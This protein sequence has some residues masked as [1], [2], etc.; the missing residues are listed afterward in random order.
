MDPHPPAGGLPLIGLT[1]VGLLPVELTLL[2]R[3][4][5]LGLAL[6][7]IGRSPDFGFSGCFWNEPSLEPK[8][9]LTEEPTL[10]R[11]A[12]GDTGVAGE[13]GVGDATVG[14]ARRAG[15]AGVSVAV[16]DVAAAAR[17]WR[18]AS[19]RELTSDRTPSN[20]RKMD[21]DPAANADDTASRVGASDS[22]RRKSCNPSARRIPMSETGFTLPSQGCRGSLRS[23]ITGSVAASQI[24]YAAEVRNAA[25]NASPKGTNGFDS[26]DTPA[27]AP[28]FF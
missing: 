14:V 1:F 11:V 20:A 10:A 13:A 21:A 5:G 24:S 27:A 19:M 15:W 18:S 23:K 26:D 12:S 8:K 4:L 7:L 28:P 2:L 9:P 22:S 16:G 17:R 3:R 25:A 6:R